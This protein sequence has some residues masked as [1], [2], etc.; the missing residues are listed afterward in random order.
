MFEI[1]ALMILLFTQPSRNP[2]KSIVAGAGSIAS[3]ASGMFSD[4]LSY[5]RLWAVGLA[6]SKVAGAFNAIGLM[7][8]EKMPFALG[9]VV[10]VI[11]FVFGHSLNIILS[12]I[13]VLAH[14]VRLNLLEFTNHLGLEWSGREYEPFKEE[15]KN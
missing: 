15:N 9:V 3:N 8:I 10:L 7:A 13:S 1:S 11:V 2:I 4:I 12:C 6:G 5:I 14:G